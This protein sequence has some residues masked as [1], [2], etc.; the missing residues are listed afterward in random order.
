MRDLKW[1]RGIRW[2]EIDDNLILRHV[3][4]KRQKEIEVDLKLAPMVMEE[5]ALLGERQKSGPL[6]VNQ[7][8]ELPLSLIHI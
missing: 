2:S 6:I 7:A 1:L 4:S 5:L 3:T 8:T